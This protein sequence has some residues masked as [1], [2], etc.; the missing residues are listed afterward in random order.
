MPAR[1]CTG[2]K[3]HSAPGAAALGAGRAPSAPFLHDLSPPLQGRGPRLHGSPWQRHQDPPSCGTWEEPLGPGPPHPLL[4]CPA[5]SPSP[6]SPLRLQIKGFSIPRGSACL[7]GPSAGERGGQGG[8]SL[9]GR[10]RGPLS[11]WVPM[12][13]VS[14]QWAWGS[15]ERWVLAALPEVPGGLCRSDAHKLRFGWLC[16]WG[17]GSDAQEHRLWVVLWLGEGV[18]VAGSAPGPGGDTCAGGDRPTSWRPR[19]E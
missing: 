8:G 9:A 12:V 14:V 5:F 15:G 3:V 10:T 16:G 19:W 6:P 18:R 7:W 1:L 13:C 4:P 17:E 2:R 11:S